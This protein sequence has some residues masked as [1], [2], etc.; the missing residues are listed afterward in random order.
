M[1]VGLLAWVGPSARA[2]EPVVTTL[3]D[4]ENDSVAARLGAT[5]DISPA[6]CALRWRAV[7]ARG[8]NA[9][10]LELAATSPNVSV[11]CDLV[12][13]LSTPFASAER[14][15]IFVWSQDGDG[16]LHFRVRD[17]RDALYETGAI[18]FTAQRRW[19]RLTSALTDDKLVRVGGDEAV[20]AA[21][22]WPLEFV[23]VRVVSATPGS[24]AILLD[25]FEVEHALPAVR[26]IAGDFLLDR[27]THL[28][29]P[30]ATVQASLRLENLSRARRLDLHVQLA[31][32]RADG[33]EHARTQSA[34]TL[35]ASGADFRASQRVDFSQKL[36][37]PGLYR[38]VARVRE[39]SATQ[40]IEFETTIAVM[41]TNR[42]V[43][44]GRAIFFGV[45][46]NLLREPWLDQLLEMQVARELGVQ[47]LALETPWSL[48]EP[49]AGSL[50]FGELDRVLETLAR[51]DIAVLIELSEPPPWAGANPSAE[52]QAGV[53]EALVRRYGARVALYRPLRPSSAT[54]TGEQVAAIVALQQRLVALQKDVRVV[55]PAI[56]IDAGT[57]IAP[58]WFTLS[59]ALSAFRAGGR[60][61]DAAGVLRAAAERSQARWGDST[62]WEYSAES[63]S[64]PGA[65]EDSLALVRLYLHAR[66]A[67]AGALIWDELRDD[68]SDPRRRET[69]HG[70]FRRDFSP[71]TTARALATTVRMLAGLLYAG[72]VSGAPPEFESAVFLSGG[73]QVALLI[74]RPNRILPALLAPQAAVDGDVDVIDFRLQPLTATAGEPTLALTPASPLFVTLQTQRAFDQPQLHFGKPWLRAPS[75]VPCGIG[76]TPL[77]VEID[78]PVAL[79]NA[80]LQVSLPEPGPVRSSIRTRTLRGAPGETVRT[81]IMLTRATADAFTPLPL[82]LRVSIDGANID[83]PI[84]LR[85]QAALPLTNEGAPGAAL[86]ALS[87]AGDARSNP[88][89][90]VRAGAARGM[91]R[92]AIELPAGASPDGQLRVGVAREGDD[93]HMELLIV[94]GAA[95]RLQLEFAQQHV[96]LAGCTV[97][98]AD[99]PGARL[100]YGLSLPVQ[101]L[102]WDEL[103]ADRRLRL[104][105][106][107]DEPGVGTRPA[108]ALVWG[109]GLDGSRSSGE[110]HWI[111]LTTGG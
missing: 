22:Q 43:S 105:V 15:A 76:E 44:R 82:S 108:R 13:R 72:P 100:T 92:L 60:P 50:S 64:G 29:A 21:P 61:D 65:V 19:V 102:G 24:K 7:P 5:R 77:V 106:R 25:D 47:M 32:L 26:V 34:L 107:F 8:Q 83:V 85:P 89:G 68:S 2:D 69:Q 41:P 97:A 14:A 17:A 58:E 49:H 88:L 75:V 95:P 66:A 78:A 37:E 33:V 91:L 104:A 28:Y 3:A 4:F 38:L 94:P 48:I 51:F 63:L 101:G 23:G 40:V 42:D 12:F 87:V 111:R 81:E 96:S 6:D 70:L 57:K 45:R 74:P 93:S 56:P 52:Q 86:G 11:V 18:R 10:A 53:L 54:P 31:W 20:P 80:Y 67:G 98:Q 46:T 79:A 16:A 27:P 71:R 62:L 55:A 36:D 103:K 99:E 90:Q 84:T 110:F 1:L 30:G 59:P 109:G 9:L 39:R 73:R 35:Q